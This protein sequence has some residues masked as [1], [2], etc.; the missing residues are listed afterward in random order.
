MAA[1]DK[2]SLQEICSFQSM[3]HEDLVV[4]RGCTVGSS[5]GDGRLYI[6]ARDGNSNRWFIDWQNGRWHISLSNKTYDY[7]EGKLDRIANVISSDYKAQ[8]SEI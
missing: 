3:L 2:L 4:K 1:K 5:Y 7:S 6:V 8:K